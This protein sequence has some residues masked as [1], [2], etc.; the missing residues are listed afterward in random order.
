MIS[1]CQKVDKGADAGSK[2]VVA[3]IDGV[4][5]LDVLGIVVLEHCYQPP[6]IEVRLHMILTDASKAETGNTEF[7]HR[8]TVIGEQIAADDPD[9]MGT[10]GRIAKRPAL[11]GRAE[12]EGQA[13]VAVEIVGCQGRPCR[14]R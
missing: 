5:R 10:A 14:T 13:I 4:D 6:F 9:E 7:A 3:G 12:I 11:G 1:R 2:M 8:R